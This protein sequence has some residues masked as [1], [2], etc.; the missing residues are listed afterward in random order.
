MPAHVEAIVAEAD[1]RGGL[2]AILLTHDHPDH[3]EAVAP[4]RA[5]T[6]APLAA[7][8]ADADIRLADGARLGPFTAIATSGH[9]P[10]HLAFVSAGVCYSGDAVLGAGSVFMSPHPGSL[11]A[12]LDALSRL[13]ALGLELIAPGHGPLVTEPDAKL[14]AYIE[15]RRERERAL[16]AALDDGL[17]DHDEL[18]DRV[19]VGVPPALRPIARATLEAHLDKLAAEGRLPN[20]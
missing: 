5:R 19:W 18:L 1:A 10:D 7:A 20:V 14:A 15:H 13:R 16:V 17:R 2:A 12:Y 11:A 3:A 9:A 6:R 4:L 8:A